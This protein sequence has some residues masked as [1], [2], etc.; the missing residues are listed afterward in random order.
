[1]TNFEDIKSMNIEE[2]ARDFIFFTPNNANFHYTGLSNKYRKTTR[3]V[4]EDNLKW[5]NSEV[6]EE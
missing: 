2:M 5:L 3:E 1:M 6:G 4:I